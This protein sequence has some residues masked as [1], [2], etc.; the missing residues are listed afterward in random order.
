MRVPLSRLREKGPHEVG[1]DEGFP[2]TDRARDFA[3]IDKESRR[4][5]GPHPT[6]AHARATFSHFV[7]EGNALNRSSSPRKDVCLP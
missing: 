4:D 6:L 2:S 5:A 1:S 7:G 3:Q